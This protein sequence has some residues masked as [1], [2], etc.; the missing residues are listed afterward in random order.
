M[1]LAV[2]AISPPASAVLRVRTRGQAGV[3][4]CPLSSARCVNNFI[5]SRH[6]VH[7][8]PWI[9]TRTPANKAVRYTVEYYCEAPSSIE[10]TRGSGPEPREPSRRGALCLL[11]RRVFP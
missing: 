10:A 1:Q 5:W 6:T 11:V 7:P 2:G 9:L 3:V 8:F 4:Q